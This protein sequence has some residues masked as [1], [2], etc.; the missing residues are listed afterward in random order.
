MR[1]A[2][3]AGKRVVFTNGVF[4]LL[5]VGH[6]RYLEEARRLGDVLIVGLNSDASTRAIKG[7]S[8]P[9]LPQAERE[10][11]LLA[12]KCIDAVVVFDEPTADKTIEALRPDVYVKGGDYAAQ[13][14]PE[15]PT[16]E[17][18]GGQ[19]RILQLVE[20]RSTSDVIETIRQRFCR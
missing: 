8:R 15:T 13:G 18:Y 12:L 1:E 9:L 4:D 2:R 3:Q 7:A 17:R 19:V 6:V 16:V 20:G 5:H 10:E 14:P 11:L